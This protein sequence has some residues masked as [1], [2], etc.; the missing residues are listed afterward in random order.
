MTITKK[1]F[2]PAEIEKVDRALAE[3]RQHLEEESVFEVLFPE[4]HGEYQRWLELVEQ[5]WKVMKAEQGNKQ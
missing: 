2:T 4:A 3:M 5:D 1:Q